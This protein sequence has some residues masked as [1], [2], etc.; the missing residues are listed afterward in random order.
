VGLLVWLGS[1]IPPA[2]QPASVMLSSR[3]VNVMQ[4]APDCAAQQP[5]VVFTNVALGEY[6]RL[7][8]CPGRPAELV[9][10]PAATDGGREPDLEL[11]VVDEQ[12]V[13]ILHQDD[14][15]PPVLSAS[16]RDLGR[17]GPLFFCL[18]LYNTGLCTLDAA[19]VKLWSASAIANA[20][21]VHATHPGLRVTAQSLA[22][23][24]SAGAS[25]A[26]EATPG[27][28][29]ITLRVQPARGGGAAPAT[30]AARPGR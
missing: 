1:R 23:G 12:L 15:N 7:P 24:A 16:A 8:I 30:P 27:G 17:A 13:Q 11:Y 18:Q 6:R 20:A 26:S 2:E 4:A 21:L 9:T 3:L 5:E 19:A 25:E 28:Y 14:P 10:S 29:T 22:A